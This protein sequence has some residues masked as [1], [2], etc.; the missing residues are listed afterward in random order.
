MATTK[1]CQPARDPTAQQWQFAESCLNGLSLVDAFVQAY[2]AHGPRSRECERVKAKRMAKNPTVV[3][4]MQQIAKRRAEEDAVENP[5]QVRK[6]CLITLRRIRQGQLDSSYARAV[7]A[8]LREANREIERRGEEAHRQE[9]TQRNALERALRQQ[10]THDL[11]VMMTPSGKGK[12]VAATESRASSAGGAV[13]PPIVPP[14][15]QHASPPKPAAT[16]T[17]PPAAPGTCPDGELHH[18]Q[19]VRAPESDRKP[20][21][22]QNSQTEVRYL[23]G[24]FPPKLAWTA[25]AVPDLRAMTLPTFTAHRTGREVPVLT[26][27]RER[28]VSDV[29]RS[30]ARKRKEPREPY[31]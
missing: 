21:P 23:P 3:W 28:R 30:Y 19:E 5:E 22:A 6:E 4:A 8:E 14:V 27:F 7:L 10:F 12:T 15:P 20:A 2:P 17:Q 29:D 31:Y 13:A 18:G 9:C 1:V 25:G 11:K 26:V 16:P 24:H